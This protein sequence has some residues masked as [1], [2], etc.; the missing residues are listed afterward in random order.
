MYSPP[1]CQCRSCGRQY[2]RDRLGLVPPEGVAIALNPELGYLDPVKMDRLALAWCT[3]RGLVAGPG[4]RLYL[5]A[6]VFGGSFEGYVY[7][8]LSEQERDDELKRLLSDVMGLVS[9]DR[10]AIERLFSL[11]WRPF[12][13]TKLVDPGELSDGEFWERAD[14]YIAHT[15]E[16][17]YR[18][19]EIELPVGIVLHDSATVRVIREG[20]AIH[21]VEG[22]PPGWDYEIVELE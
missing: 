5:I 17:E 21:D 6:E 12:Q 10:T 16:T 15:D 9:K 20:G 8:G 3:R 11:P 1:L 7:A 2:V 13:R 4:R 14:D 18:A 22:L 19:D